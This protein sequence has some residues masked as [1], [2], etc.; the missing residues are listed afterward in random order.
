MGFALRPGALSVGL[1][2]VCHDAGGAP[3]RNEFVT[4]R[5]KRGRSRSTSS[6]PGFAFGACARRERS[7]RLARALPVSPRRGWLVEGGTMT[8]PRRQRARRARSV[9]RRTARRQIGDDGASDDGLSRERRR[10][11]ARATTALARATSSRAS[12]QETSSHTRGAGRCPVGS[13]L[14]GRP[15]RAAA[16]PSRTRRGSAPIPSGRCLVV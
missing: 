11:L 3:S 12:D 5:A 14:P 13:R 2:A 10:A 9:R 6:T 16:V 4:S 15:G 7:S 1:R 8:Q